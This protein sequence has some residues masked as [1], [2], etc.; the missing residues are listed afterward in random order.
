MVSGALDG[1]PV[2]G[3][4]SMDCAVRTVMRVDTPVVPVP[5]T[6]SLL[7]CSP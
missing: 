4:D 5:V 2:V 7:V 6:V 3:D 1:C